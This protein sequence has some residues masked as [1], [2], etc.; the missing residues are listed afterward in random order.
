MEVA[1]GSRTCDGEPVGVY[2]ET[3][4][5]TYF[6]RSGCRSRSRWCAPSM[7]A[8]TGTGRRPAIIQSFETG[9]LRQLNR[10]TGVRLAQLV[11]CQGAPY[12]LRAAGDP[13]TYA[14]LVTPAGLTE[15]ARYADGVGA[16]KHLIIP[17]DAAGN[18]LAPTAV[19]RDA[20]RRGL[21]VHGWTF[22]RENQ[23]LP[24]DFRDRHRPRRVGDLE[25]EIQAFLDT[26]MDGF[27]TDNPDVGVAA[28]AG[29]R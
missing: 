12:D 14:D 3:K 11:D 9:N 16:C 21:V 17:R 4:H 27:F 10:L 25:S 6:D 20:H 13:R 1:R 19:V 29:W 23:F 8:A 26:G 5:P 15:I 18:L 22:R 7:P 24:L 28:V 2:P